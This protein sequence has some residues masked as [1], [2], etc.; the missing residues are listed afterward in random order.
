VRKSI[1]ACVAVALIVGTTSATAATLVTG[2]QVKD[3]SLTGADVKNG[4]LRKADLSDKAINSLKGKNGATGP[5]GAAGAKGEVGPAGLAGKEGVNGKDGKDGK[6]AVVTPVS[7]VFAPTTIVDIGGSITARQTPLGTL[8]LDPGTYIVT[9]DAAF[10]STSAGDAAVEVYP[11]VSLFIDKDDDGRL[12]YSTDPMVNEGDIS[13]NA[14][15]PTAA[16]RHISTSGI[17]QVTL[18]AGQ[19]L[20][21]AAFGYTSTQGNE[22][23][24]QIKVVRAVIGALPVA[25]G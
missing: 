20:G 3:G 13:P 24:G 21:L 10:E 22:R 23:S 16:N 11:Q 15:M 9:V 1:L 7:K 25:A 19:K 14:I 2:K 6:D 4:S 12:D 18:T 17:T 5:Q 8:E